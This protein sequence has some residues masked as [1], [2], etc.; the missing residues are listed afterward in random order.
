M[1]L[2]LVWQGHL[3][4]QVEKDLWIAAGSHLI[5][6][7]HIISRS[8]LLAAPSNSW[9]WSLSTPEGIARLSWEHS[10]RGYF[11]HSVILMWLPYV[12]SSLDSASVP[13]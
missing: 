3:M 12:L 7:K 11:C 8:K 9:G 6:C 1:A 5:T 13:L 10:S 4:E 2:P